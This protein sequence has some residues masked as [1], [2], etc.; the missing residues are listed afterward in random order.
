VVK[1]LE[2]LR[3]LVGEIQ[4]LN[5]TQGL[6]GWDLETHMPEKGSD[7]RA[8][9]M[10][11]LSKISHE[12]MISK[13][14]GD[15]LKKLREPS[16]YDKLNKVDQALVR[17]VGKDYDRAMKLPVSLVQEMTEI[18][19]K[20]HPLWVE[21]R[22]TNK[23]EKFA[24]TLKRIVELNRQM[25]K[26]LGY[27]DSPY[28]ALLDLYE[29]G[30]TCKKLDQ[31][32]PQLKAELVPLVKAI[33]DSPRQPDTRFLKRVTSVDK[34]WE[35]S[36]KVIRSMGF[37]FN[38][39]RLDK[40][41]HPFCMGMGP[42]DVR[43]TTRLFKNDMVSSLFSSMHEAGHG[44]YEQG[45]DPSLA[46]TPLDGGA[47]LGIH[48]SQSRM[49]ENIIGRSRLFWKYYLP[50]L[51]KVFP[52]QLKGVTLDQFYRAINLSQPS[53]VRVE[54]D[55]ATYN[56]HIMLRYEIERD[57]IE[58]KLAVKDLP[59]VW[60]Q[61]MKE[62]LGIVPESDTL[63]VLQDVHWAHGSFGYFPT[64]T[65][66]NLYSVQF[67]NTA[68]KKIRGLEEQIARGN[69][70]PLKAWLNDNIH[71]WSKVETPEE[72]AIRVTGEPLNARHF[73]DYLW[74][75]YGEIYQFERAGSR[76]LQTASR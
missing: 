38:A 27:K 11:T 31:L 8:K 35:F 26:H 57:V 30:L 47:S 76:Q 58:G 19:A 67:Y 34:Q 49:W 23:F 15:L 65:L 54:S 21:A 51:R 40:A 14:M 55:E 20:A 4:D 62:Y 41:A 64:Y 44:L 5:S 56:L 60:N 12:M 32:F 18:S 3:E 74:N 53:F 29:P 39:G 69:F 71:R 13:E 43:L 42:G 70:K 1:E 48:E 22:Q 63:G 25:A 37:D 17:E 66:G 46:R 72:I 28:D 68:K 10:S 7:I 45:V 59:K 16:V 75:K 24:P 2:A 52:Q 36:E 9:Q 33:N 50:K 61:K 73:V 6:L